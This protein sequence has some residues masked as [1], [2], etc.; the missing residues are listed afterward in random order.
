MGEVCGL[1][2]RPAN[3]LIS[4]GREQWRLVEGSPSQLGKVQRDR[5]SGGREPGEGLWS[6]FWSLGDFSV[7]KRKSLGRLVVCFVV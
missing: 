4:V 2:R 3:K 7:G 6:S 5:S 1:A